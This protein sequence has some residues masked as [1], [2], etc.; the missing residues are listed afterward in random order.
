MAPG[1]STARTRPFVFDMDAQSAPNVGKLSTVRCD[2]RGTPAASQPLW[3]SAL[4]DAQ[5][6]E[7]GQYLIRG[8]LSLARDFREQRTP[9]QAF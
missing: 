5:Q 9:P 1:R 7:R 8:E 4:H 6:A 2:H 3:R